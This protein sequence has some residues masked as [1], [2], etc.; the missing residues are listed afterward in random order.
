M[1]DFATVAFPFTEF[2]KGI[3]VTLYDDKGK[4]R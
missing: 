2:P 1:L 3:D 4:K